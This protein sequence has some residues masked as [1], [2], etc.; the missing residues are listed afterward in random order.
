LNG[1]VD[2]RGIQPFLTHRLSRAV[3]AGLRFTVAEGVIELAA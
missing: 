1:A 2:A 3:N